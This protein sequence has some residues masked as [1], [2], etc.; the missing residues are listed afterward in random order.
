MDICQR[1]SSAPA[2]NPATTP[3]KSAAPSRTCCASAST[4]QSSAP[5]TAAPHPSSVTPLR[6]PTRP[7]WRQHAAV[8]ASARSWRLRRTRARW[9]GSRRRC[10]AGGGRPRRG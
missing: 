2:P 5:S 1:I 10:F 8:T 7:T 6:W 9:T 3:Q 4:S